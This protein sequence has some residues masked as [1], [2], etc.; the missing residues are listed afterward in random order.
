M[1]HTYPLYFKHSIEKM[2]LSGLDSKKYQSILQFKR[3]LTDDSLFGTVTVIPEKLSDGN[4]EIDEY[5]E[6]AVK[7]LQVKPVNFS[8][9]QMRTIANL[10]RSGESPNK[11]AVKFNCCEFT[12][13]KAL[14]KQN[15]EI[16]KCPAQAKVDVEAAIKKAL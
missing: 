12:I 3:T 13:R 7:Q 8:Q 4:R 11:I 10:Y 16:V 15:I 5:G 14:K 9:D 6:V 1:I 2:L